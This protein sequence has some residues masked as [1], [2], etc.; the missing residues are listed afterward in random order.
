MPPFP[1]ASRDK[2]DI[3]DPLTRDTNV[4]TMPDMEI[5]TL[6]TQLSQRRGQWTHLADVAGLSRKT[7]QRI[8]DDPTYNPTL[9][10]VNALQAAIAADAVD[11]PIPVS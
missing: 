10:T 1:H 6:R 7:I 11:R 2:W 9:A 3:C 4:P 8:V 5:D